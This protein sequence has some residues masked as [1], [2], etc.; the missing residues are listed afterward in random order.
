MGIQ[1]RL[2]RR[3]EQRGRLSQGKGSARRP[4]RRFRDEIRLEPTFGLQHARWNRVR[5]CQSAEL[6]AAPGASL[7]LV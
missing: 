3:V 5:Q 4:T 7:G 6:P 2:S 1:P